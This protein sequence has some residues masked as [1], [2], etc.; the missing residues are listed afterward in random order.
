MIRER[1]DNLYR[2]VVDKGFLPNLYFRQRIFYA[3]TD[4][5]FVGGTL[6]QG[7]EEIKQTVTKLLVDKP[8]NKLVNSR[9]PDEGPHP[10]GHPHAGSQGFCYVGPDREVARKVA[11]ALN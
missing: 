2:Q 8:L 10:V 11:D 9:D 1:D 6:A 5:L 7:S 4:K 3:R